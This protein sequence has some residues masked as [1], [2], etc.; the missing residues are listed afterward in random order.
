M[1]E[2]AIEQYLVKQT[3]KY[4]GLCWKWT[5]P[6]RIGVPDRIVMFKPGIICFVELKAPGKT[7]RKSQFVAQTKLRNKGFTVFSSVDSKERVDSI[8]T[9]CRLMSLKALT[10]MEKNRSYEDD[11]K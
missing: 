4:G 5:S 2:N 11:L 9:Y 10:D 6:G 8:L 1:T 7:E 3:E